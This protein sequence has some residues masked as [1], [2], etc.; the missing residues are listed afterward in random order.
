VEADQRGLRR[1]E[2]QWKKGKREGNGTMRL[3][4]SDG[5]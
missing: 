5:Q 4:K 2:A 3:G 1:K